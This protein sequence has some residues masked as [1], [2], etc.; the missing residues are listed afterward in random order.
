MPRV[1]SAYSRNWDSLEGIFQVG[2]HMEVENEDLQG[3]VGVSEGFVGVQAM[4]TTLEM[5]CKICV[6]SPDMPGILDDVGVE[7]DSG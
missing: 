2:E 4:D 3:Q 7:A 5:I 6:R 1:V